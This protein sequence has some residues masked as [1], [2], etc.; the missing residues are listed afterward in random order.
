MKYQV[1][2]KEKARKELSSLP[3]KLQRRI[4]GVLTLLA[5]DPYP[6]NAKKLIGREGYR[7]RT[8]DYRIIYCVERNVLLV[9]VIKIGHRK[10]IYK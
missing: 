8:G 10:D 4:G 7:I 2:L 9:I 1:V 5:L 3:I 6:R